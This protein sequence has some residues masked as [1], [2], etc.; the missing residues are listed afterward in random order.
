M[1][2]ERLAESGNRKTGHVETGCLGVPHLL[3]AWPWARL[4][5]LSLRLWADA[6]R[7]P[8]KT[9]LASQWPADTG[10]F[11][12]CNQ[13]S[14]MLIKIQ[15]CRKYWMLRCNY[16]HCVLI[17]KEQ[18][19]WRSAVLHRSSSVWARCGGRGQGQAKA[20]GTAK[21]VV[22]AAPRKGRSHSQPVPCFP[23]VPASLAIWSPRPSK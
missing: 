4:S 14:R 12:F 23:T 8:W 10:L 16:H 20:L 19:V 21:A 6:A 18:L 3:V 1:L 5:L 11:L 13:S 7:L 2:N 9:P 22:G 17:R 15:R